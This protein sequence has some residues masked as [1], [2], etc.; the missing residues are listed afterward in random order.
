MIDYLGAEGTKKN[1]G[2]FIGSLQA[3]IKDVDTNTRQK[4]EKTTYYSLFIITEGSL[5]IGIEFETYTA[6][7]GQI[8]IL[9]NSRRHSIH[10][11]QGAKGYIIM[12]TEGFTCEYF[13]EEN[14]LVKT[15]FKDSHMSPLIKSSDLYLGVMESLIDTLITVY[16]HKSPII[17]NQVISRAFKPLAQLIVNIQNSDDTYDYRKNH[18][19]VEFVELVEAYVQYKH[20]VDDYAEMMHV[21]TKTINQVTRKG[22]GMSAKSYIISQL[23]QKIKVKLSF[24]RQSI[25]EIAIEMGFTEPSNMTRLF[26]KNEGMTPK[27]FRSKYQNDKG[28]AL[29]EGTMDLDLFKNAIEEKV[30]HISSSLQV[31]MHKHLGHDE[32]F[33]CIMGEGFG[34]LENSELPLSVGKV[35]PVKSGTLHALRSDT[36]LYVVAV[37]IPVVEEYYE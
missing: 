19:F 13:N 15:M 35:F 8:L 17:D 26:K 28:N 36:D 20:G 14:D 32:V 2:F 1:A 34:L 12:F 31:P 9:S 7:E 25:H 21:S 18:L 3:H 10:E 29:I 4:Q 5:T 30:Y 23:I 11:N 24:Q 22:V 27:D 33:Y 37:L 16:S 6:Y